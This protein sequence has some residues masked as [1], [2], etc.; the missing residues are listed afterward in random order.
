MKHRNG[1]R[2][3]QRRGRKRMNEPKK[4]LPSKL[5]SHSSAY[6]RDYI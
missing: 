4:S 3:R 1:R 2:K 5:K 6:T